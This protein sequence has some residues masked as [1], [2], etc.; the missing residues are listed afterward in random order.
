MWEH[1]ELRAHGEAGLPAL[2]Y[3]PGLHGDWTLIG[4]F[5]A[6]VAGRIRLVEVTY[7]RTVTWSLT[8][9]AGA[10]LDALAA[11]A[12]HRGWLLGES[13]GSQV[14]WRILEKAS[15]WRFQAEGLILAGGFVRHPVIWGVRAARLSNLML[16]RRCL[17][18]VFGLYG[19]YARLRHRRAPG[20]ASEIPEFIRRRA[21]EADRQA[22]CHRYTLIAGEDL[23]PVA[24]AA[25]LPVWQLAGLFD[26]IVPWGPVR[27]WLRRRCPG[28]RGWR[29]LWHADHT[30]L[31]T[32]PQ[33]SARQIMAWMGAALR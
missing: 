9:Y 33:A 7:P 29:L 17:P 1:L 4:A 8:D 5:R 6:A 18:A 12:L 21:E 25:R 28:Y 32:A 30:V 19:W 13:F 16:P 31:A 24:R 15:A 23:R 10:V 14:A 2:V 3:L 20:V 11:Q 26:P 22:I 27:W